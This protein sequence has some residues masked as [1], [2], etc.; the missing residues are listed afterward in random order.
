MDIEAGTRTGERDDIHESLT[1]SFE[2]RLGGYDDDPT[3][4]M[5]SMTEGKEKSGGVQF[6]STNSIAEVRR[7]SRISNYDLEEV[8]SY[9]GDSSEHKLRK[10]ELRKAAHEMQCRRMSDNN[11]FTT[12]GITDK[13]GEGRLLKKQNR[14]SATTA[15]LDEQ[16]LQYHEGVYD[17][18]LLADVYTITTVSA[19]KTAQQSAAALHQEV[20]KF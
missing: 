8:I 5:T 6:R 12:L 20:S 19:K 4:M 16:D 14:K 1:S 10:K 11:S 17:D 13:V 18:E 15:V 2:G 7:I 3:M 9:W